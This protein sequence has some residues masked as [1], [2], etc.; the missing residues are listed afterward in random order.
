MKT[1]EYKFDKGYDISIVIDGKLKRIITDITRRN[2]KKKLDKLNE[3]LIAT[4]NRG[5][6][7]LHE[8]NS[9]LNRDVTITIDTI[10]EVKHN[11]GCSGFALNN[12]IVFINGEII[13]LEQKE[14]LKETPAIGKLTS[15]ELESVISSDNE[16]LIYNWLLNEYCYCRSENV[17][18]LFEPIKYNIVELIR[19]DKS[20]QDEFK[21]NLIETLNKLK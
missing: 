19:N 3:Y 2:D 4:Y 18:L 6:I 12:V 5:I 14:E 10:V 16:Q 7:E 8:F 13:E 17:K 9:G 20:L 1:R 15:N 21:L 11:S